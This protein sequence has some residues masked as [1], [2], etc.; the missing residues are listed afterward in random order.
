[1][2]VLGLGGWV[3]FGDSVKDKQAV[4]RIFG[5]AFDAGVNF[6]DTAE[7]YGPYVAEELLKEALH[8]YADDIVIATKSGLT[9]TGPNQWPPLGR[10]EFLRQ[11]AEMSLRRL[12]LAGD[13]TPAGLTRL[14]RGL[15]SPGSMTGGAPP[16]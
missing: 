10:P 1:M 7:S 4:D 16:S 12:G 6:F 13:S 3:T 15:T 2:S 14:T 8:P 11:G 5:A 9:R